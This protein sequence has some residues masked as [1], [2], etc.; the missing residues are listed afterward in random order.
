MEIKKKFLCT[1][2]DSKIIP[3]EKTYFDFL[4]RSNNKEF[5]VWFYKPEKIRSL[6]ENR[7]YR[8]V[9]IKKLSD[10]TG[11]NDNEM[12]NILRYKFL[13]KYHENHKIPPIARST[14]E[15]TTVEFEEYLT[16]IRE[17]ASIDLGCYIPL[18][19]EAVY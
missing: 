14:T 4:E 13:L 18:P 19:N 9:V 12:H 3:Q 17:W 16:K 1:I 2:I 8:G 6:S 15:L 10:F 7:Y 11:Y 5:Y